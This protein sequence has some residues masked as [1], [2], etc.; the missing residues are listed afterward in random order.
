LKEETTASSFQVAVN[1]AEHALVNSAERHS[2]MVEAAKR[3]SRPLT[4]WVQVFSA[5]ERM[6]AVSSP[7]A[8]GALNSEPTTEKRN[9]AHKTAVDRSCLEVIAAPHERGGRCL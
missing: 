7:R 6:L 3:T 2:S 5:S 9:R 1:L 4:G 8:G